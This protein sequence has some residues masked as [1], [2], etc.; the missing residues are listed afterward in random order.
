MTTEKKYTRKQAHAWR[1]Q[2]RPYPPQTHTSSRRQLESHWESQ[3][4][5]KKYAYVYRSKERQNDLCISFSDY[6]DLIETLADD[7][8]YLQVSD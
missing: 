7:R 3:D 5:D 4:I 2:T 6:Q 1:H 8:R